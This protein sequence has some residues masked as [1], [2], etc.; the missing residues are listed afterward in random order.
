MC[1][2]VSAV[3]SVENTPTFCGVPS[4]RAGLA[5]LTCWIGVSLSLGFRQSVAPSCL[6]SSNLDGLVSIAKIREAFLALAACHARIDERSGLEGGGGGGGAYASHLPSLVVATL[7]SSSPS[8]THGNCSTIARL[9]YT[10]S[11]RCAIDRS[12]HRRR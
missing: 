12:K 10:R 5:W 4:L 2:G 9:L 1:G 7:H 3:N 6:A 11:L 8:D